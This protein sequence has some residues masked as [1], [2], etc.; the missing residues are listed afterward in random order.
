MIAIVDYGM[1]NIH[2]VK[3][4]IDSFALK[5]LIA[6]KG[7]DLEQAEKI[8]LPGVGAFADAMKE[9]KQR[10]LDT[11]IIEQIKHKKPFLGICLGMQLLFERSDEAEG[12]AGL[13]VFA[14]RVKKLSN[15]GGL[16]IPHIG[17]NQL[18]KV[19]P[20]C[21]LLKDIPDNAYVY[22]CH[23][24][25]A[26]VRDKEVIAAT[27]DYGINF[28]SLIGKGNVFAVQFHPEKSQSVGI[29]ILENFLNQC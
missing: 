3:K 26:E 13:R 11:A 14:G 6:Q 23:S 4:V 16:R 25:Y 15:L 7:S 12:V 8:I 9:L 21:P 17:W 20:E 2:S 24:Y 18:K 27:T 1:G 5:Y 19:S 10:K 29:K 22:F 28:T